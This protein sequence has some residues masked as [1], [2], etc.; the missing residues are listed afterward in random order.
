MKYYKEEHW[1]VFYRIQDKK[2][3]WVWQKHW[4]RIWPGDVFWDD[5]D[6]GGI[7]KI[8]EQEAFVGIL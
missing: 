1:D 3:A 8:T 2:N 6:M 7:V 5:I 4:S